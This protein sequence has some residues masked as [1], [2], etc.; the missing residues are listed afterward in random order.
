MNPFHLDPI[1]HAAPNRI[2]CRFPVTRKLVL[3]ILAVG[4]IFFGVAP[5][6]FAAASTIHEAASNNDL[7]KLAEFI[8][9]P[10]I[11]DTT[12][13]YGWQ[14]IHVAAEKG[15][16]KAVSQLLK[17]GASANAVRKTPSPSEGVSVKVSL[18]AG[19]DTPLHCAARSG[20]VE[21]VELLLKAGA[22]IDAQN[23]VGYRPIYGAVNAGHAKV[24]AA[25]LKAGVP[26]DRPYKASFVC[27]GLGVKTG[28]MAHVAADKGH[29]DVLRLLIDAGCPIASRRD[30]GRG[31]KPGAQP[32][33]LAVKN[34]RNDVVQLLLK[35]IAKAQKKKASPKSKKKVLDDKT[36]TR[37]L[38]TAARYDH[39]DVVSTLLK[40]GADP[41]GVFPMKSFGAAPEPWQAIHYAANANGQGR[42]VKVL[43]KAGASPIAALPDGRQPLH[44]AALYG[45]LGSIRELLKAGAA[46]DAKTKGG[47]TPMQIAQAFRRKEAAG[48]LK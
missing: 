38:C 46:R 44:L 20:N 12:D 23:K 8:K 31:V 29:T 4:L 32:I 6:A 19:G 18:L 33:D 35:T 11:L 3:S 27:C 28:H 47:V 15:H 13:S 21:L 26:A 14:A 25:M 39:A 48:L 22:N 5:S 42:A 41:K 17:A 9:K 34:G 24:V 30:D 37:L 10:G 2:S 7:P 16:I 40:A 43:I 1:R 36:L 45:R